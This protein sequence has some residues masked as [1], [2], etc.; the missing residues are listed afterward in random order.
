M[1]GLGGGLVN[2]GLNVV[3]LQLA[4]R[5]PENSGARFPIPDKFR[6]LTTR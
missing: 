5:E 4:A 1:A 2:G 3:P 6:S